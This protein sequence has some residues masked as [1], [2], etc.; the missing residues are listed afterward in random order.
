MLDAAEKLN[1][2][3]NRL[4]H[5]LDAPQIEAQARDFLSL[6]EEPEDPEEPDD[7]ETVPLIRRLRRAIVF[8]CA[9]FAGMGAFAKVERDLQ[10]KKESPEAARTD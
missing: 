8:V 2:M 5:H 10:T 6:C 7:R 1:T 4:A 9:G 3:R